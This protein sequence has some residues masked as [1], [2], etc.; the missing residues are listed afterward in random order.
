MSMVMPFGKYRNRKIEDIPSSYLKWLAEEAEDD[1]ISDAADEEYR[2]RSD[3]D[4]HWE[5]E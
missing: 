4:A 2:W 3:H 5:E 1:D